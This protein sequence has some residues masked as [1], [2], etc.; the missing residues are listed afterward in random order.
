MIKE[1]NKTPL[2]PQHE[3]QH[4][5]LEDEQIV[6][7]NDTFHSK[8]GRCI[9]CKKEIVKKWVKHDK[10]NPEDKAI[11]EVVGEGFYRER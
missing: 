6:E 1:N 11:I 7:N 2:L 9:E 10:L 8:A 5:L 4:E 3:C